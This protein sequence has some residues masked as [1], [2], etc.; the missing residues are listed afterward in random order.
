MKTWVIRMVRTDKGKKLRKAYESHQIHH[1]FNEHRTPEIRQDHVVNTI[2][3]ILKDNYL[4]EVK[5]CLES[6]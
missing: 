2:S 6:S 1:G 4:V 3:T 5:K